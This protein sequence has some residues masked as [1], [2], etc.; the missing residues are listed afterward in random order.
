MTPST[1]PPT[2]PARI[3]PVARQLAE[4]MDM[5][6]QRRRAWEK[7]GRAQVPD[8]VGRA[9]APPVRGKGGAAAGLTAL[10]RGQRVPAVS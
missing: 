6:D 9:A 4:A 1:A 2:T 10:A 3:P 7:H 8:G 5:L